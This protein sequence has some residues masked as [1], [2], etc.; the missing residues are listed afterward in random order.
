MSAPLNT[1][2]EPVAMHGPIEI[3]ITGYMILPDGRQ[4]NIRF[5]MPSGRIPTRQEI[6]DVVTAMFSPDSMRE[7]SIP[8]GT[9]PMKKPE[10]TDYIT[11]RDT[12]AAIPVP[13]SREWEPSTVDIPHDML[14][15]AIVGTGFPSPQMGA[16]YEPRGLVYFDQDDDCYEW[17]EL[18]LDKQPDEV[19]L[20]I[21]KEVA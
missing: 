19:L 9:R 8:A 18:A 6:A 15:H 5:L 16:E 13:G 4:A 20:A 3:Q 10:F 2:L 1:Q 17:D 12:G 7:S 11:K 21:Y 14:V